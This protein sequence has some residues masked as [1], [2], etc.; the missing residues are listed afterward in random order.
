[1]AFEVKKAEIPGCIENER[2]MGR[3]ETGLTD[4]HIHRIIIKVLL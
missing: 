3:L 1:M 4:Q 2:A